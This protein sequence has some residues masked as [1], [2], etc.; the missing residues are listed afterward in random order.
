MSGVN[1]MSTKD[2]NIALL[3]SLP[4]EAQEDIF[5]YLVNN[6]CSNS[7]FARKTSDQMLDDLQK[8]RLCFEQGD[9][10]NYEDALNKIS[11]KYGI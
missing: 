10:E 8:S 9:Y 7:P 11:Q 5:V 1:L 6:Y 3:S 2:I 4:E